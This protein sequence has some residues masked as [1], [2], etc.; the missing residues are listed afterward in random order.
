[1]CNTNEKPMLKKRNYTN[2][3]QL[4][5]DFD[6]ENKNLLNKREIKKA[7]KNE[8]ILNNESEEE[9]FKKPEA[10]KI[11]FTPMKKQISKGHAQTNI[12]KENGAHHNVFTTPGNSSNKQLKNQRQFKF[13]NSLAQKINFSEIK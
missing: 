7:E 3:E 6:Y 13:Q 4:A 1:M 12:K 10:I 5:K 8:L 9:S 11:S 2:F